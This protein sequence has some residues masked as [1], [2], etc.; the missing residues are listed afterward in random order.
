M[1]ILALDTATELCSVALYCDGQTFSQE[2]M[3]VNRHAE[4]LFPMIKQLLAQTN[5]KLADLDTI[6]FGSGPGSFTGVRI[7]CGIAQGLALGAD[8]TLLPVNTLE[9]LA[10]QSQQQ[11][12]ISCLDARMGEVY[13][14]A[15]HLT[16]D[17]AGHCTAIENMIEPCLIHPQQAQLFHLLEKNWTG[18]GTGF[19]TYPAQL[20]QLPIGEVVILSEILYPHARDILTC[21]RLAIQNRPN[22]C[23]PPEQAMPYYL[24]NKVAM[25]VAERQHLSNNTRAL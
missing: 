2:I 20:A 5:L 11:A 6:A 22:A 3:A 19:K 21:A 12:V 16:H 24:R 23:V 14:A 4:A 18:C 25:T 9:A 1:K 10:I 8:V 17:E 15:Y 13:Y 7:A